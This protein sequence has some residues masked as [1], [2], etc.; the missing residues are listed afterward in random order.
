MKP[1][2]AKAFYSSIARSLWFVE[3]ATSP[4]MTLTK[5]SQARMLTIALQERRKVEEAYVQGLQ[6]LARRPQQDGA[7]ALGCVQRYWEQNLG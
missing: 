3:G 4:S 5:L 1:T 2:V 7:A 6:K